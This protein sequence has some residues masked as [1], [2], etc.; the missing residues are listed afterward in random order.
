MVAK[1]KSIYADDVIAIAALTLA[2]GILKQL[3]E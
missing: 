2:Q 3:M 1:V